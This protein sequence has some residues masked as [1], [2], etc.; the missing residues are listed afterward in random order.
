MS[1]TKLA[2]VGLMVLAIPGLVQAQTVED[3]EKKLVEAH[4]KMK[5]YTSKTKT[6]QDFDMGQGIKTSADY[7]G[8][9]EWKRDGNKLKYRT[10]MK[11]VTTQSVAGQENKSEVTVLMINDGDFVYTLSDQNIPNMPPQKMASKQKPDPAMSG[12]PAKLFEKLRQD[13]D[14]KVLPDEK[15]DG[16]DVYVLEVIPKNKEDGP[17]A[18][19]LMYFAKD[20]GV[21][22]KVLGKNKDGKDV[23]TN[24]STDIKLNVDIS[25]DRFVFK[26]PEGVQVM[27]MT[28]AA[29]PTP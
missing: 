25:N 15:V 20:S 18:K 16:K 11:G 10:E 14:L 2:L 21:N 8:T 4:S 6:T 9:V 7:G 1:L 3:I 12:E 27:D 26:A 5:S 24:T 17:V 23:F 22:V 19:S 29:A 13:N 28:G